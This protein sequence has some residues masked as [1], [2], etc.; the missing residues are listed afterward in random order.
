MGHP[1][2]ILKLLESQGEKGE[3]GLPGVCYEDCLSRR[4][5][6]GPPGKRG[7]AGVQ[8][9]PGPRGLPGLTGDI[10]LPGIPVRY[11]IH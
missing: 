6:P 8:G 11:T 1:V 7:K 9:L 2:D 4:P 3:K 10:G 5:E